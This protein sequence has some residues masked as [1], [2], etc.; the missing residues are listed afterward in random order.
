M[1]T[2]TLK[3]IITAVWSGQQ[4]TAQAAGALENVGEAGEKSNKSIS[5]AALT[6]A[7]GALT[8]GAVTV[9]AKQTYRAISEGAELEL[10]RSRFDNLAESI[11]ST[12][13]AMLTRLRD[14]TGGMMS[15]AQLMASAAQIISLGLMDT[16]DGVVRLAR[17][18]GELGWDASQVILTF[19]NNSTMRLDA[20][21]LSIADVE[22]RTQKFV[23]AGHDLDTAF[24]LAVLEAGEAKIDLVGSTVGTTTQKIAR[25]EAAWENAKNAFKEQLA[26]SV[27]EEVD[28]E[29]FTSDMAETA[30]AAVQLASGL[31]KVAGAVQT[32]HERLELLQ[33]FTPGGWLVHGIKTFVIGTDEA[34]DAM[35]DAGNAATAYAG[36][37]SEAGM[38]T[39][40]MRREG[41]QTAEAMGGDVV[42]AFDAAMAAVESYTNST[43]ASSD[44]I[45]EM[46]REGIDSSEALRAKLVAD[47]EAQVAATEA[48]E[49]ATL[50]LAKSYA[51][52]FSEALANGSDGTEN[53][54]LTMLDAAVQAGANEEA[55]RLLALATGEYTEEQIEAAIKT[56]AMT[57]KAQ[58]LGV[59]VAEGRISVEDAVEALVNFQETAGKGVQLPVD[60]EEVMLA[61]QRALSAKLAMHEL[62]GTHAKVTVTTHFDQ[63]GSP[64]SGPYDTYGPG[65]AS[66]TNGWQQ[67]PGARGTPFPVTLHGGEMFNV[68]PA[69]QPAQSG[70][71][72]T[73]AFYGDINLF[74]VQD[75]RSLL[76]ELSELSV[77]G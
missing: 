67:V 3:H 36:T 43:V 68:V 17:V 29:Q 65:F 6:W 21:G 62:D 39:Y 27:S 61:E 71:N 55:L 75:S 16:E 66:G 47:Y 31:G 18:I 42:S 5:S 46:R 41:I 32:A 37:L 59:A 44:A 7:K 14:A 1:A 64:Y 50:E 51:A 10:A 54:T 48:L 69:G 77:Y 11:G 53:F 56:A 45:Y 49:E 28:F 8:L 34:S 70:G 72:S 30:V 15:D 60:S 58:E 9:A 2:E 76:E 33:M 63:V 26:I 20:L 35:G 13:D 74:E 40:E 73:Y 38:A 22:A 12:S 24:D 23:A 52:E 19:A 57:L 4:A 25:M